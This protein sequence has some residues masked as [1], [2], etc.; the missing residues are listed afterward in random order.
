MRNRPLL[1]A[2]LSWL[3]GAGWPDPGVERPGEFEVDVWSEMLYTLRA[4]RTIATER[5]QVCPPP[6]EAQRW[7]GR[8]GKFAAAA[9]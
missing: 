9:R 7:P 6:C 3:R 1:Q 8:L 5:Q 4:R 2:G